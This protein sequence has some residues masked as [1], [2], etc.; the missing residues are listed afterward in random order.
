MKFWNF[1]VFQFPSFQ[2]SK[3]YKNYKIC[4]FSSLFHRFFT[5]ISLFFHHYFI[6]FHRYFTV[7]HRYFTIFSPLF[8]RF[9]TIISPFFHRYF[10]VFS[11]FF[12]RYFTVISPFFHRYFTIFSSLFHRFFTVILPFFYLYFKPLFSFVKPNHWATTKMQKFRVSSPGID[13][14][15][16]PADMP[17]IATSDWISWTREVAESSKNSKICVSFA[18]IAHFFNAN[19]NLQKFTTTFCVWEHLQ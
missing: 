14:D 19:T 18:N 3:I 16:F 6:V 4:V 13:F 10:T 5:V 7:F 12:H 1:E 15:G 8:H 17:L 9:F 11:P 2:V